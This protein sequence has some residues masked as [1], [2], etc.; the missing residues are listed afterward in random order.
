LPGICIN[1][2]A[3]GTQV[4]VILPPMRILLLGTSV[5]YCLAA[6]LSFSF[7]KL[8]TI[9]TR[10]C[11]AKLAPNKLIEIHFTE[12]CMSLKDYLEDFELMVQSFP[13]LDF[14]SKGLRKAPGSKNEMEVPYFQAT[15][16]HTGKAYGFGP[17]PAV[18]TSGLKVANDPEPL[19]SSTTLSVTR[20]PG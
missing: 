17:Y 9:G 8:A 16:T 5:T 19:C 6:V 14:E 3:L 10:G 7:R 4:I 18:P 2:D 13:D 11:L 15:G 20:L 12:S 1:E